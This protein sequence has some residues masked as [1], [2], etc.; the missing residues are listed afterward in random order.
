MDENNFA[1]PDDLTFQS[2]LL[3]PGTIR[4]DDGS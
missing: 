3:Q 1:P 2:L 4:V